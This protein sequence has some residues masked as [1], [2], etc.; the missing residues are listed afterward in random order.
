MVRWQ[1][2]PR[3]ITWV[4]EGDCIRCT[5]HKLDNTGY[6]RMRRNKERETIARRILTRR[7]GKIPSGMT[8]R[9]TCD[10]RWCIKPDHIII[11]TL[12]QNNEDRKERGGYIGIQGENNKNSKL[13]SDQVLQIREAIGTAKE[14]AKRF[15]IHETNVLAIRKRKIWK[16]L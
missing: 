16:H 11:G 10:N 7:L 9:H 15:G 6:P 12:A 13:T 2:R 3:P 1:N 8:A 5:S 4:R 14:I